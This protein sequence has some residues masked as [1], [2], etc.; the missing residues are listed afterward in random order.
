M[1]T[2]GTRKRDERQEAK[3][4]RKCRGEERREF[5]SS[6]LRPEHGRASP[7]TAVF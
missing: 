7:V 1:V 6:K 2:A 5:E 3:K 4:P